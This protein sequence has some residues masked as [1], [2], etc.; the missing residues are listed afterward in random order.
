MS[1][2]CSSYSDTLCESCSSVSD[3]ITESFLRDCDYYS[4]SPYSV[5]S[6]VND[7]KIKEKETNDARTLPVENNVVYEGSGVPSVEEKDVV[8]DIHDE[9]NETIEGSGEIHFEPD[10]LTPN[11][12]TSVPIPVIPDESE[13][14]TEEIITTA[15]KT[16]VSQTPYPT[17]KFSVVTSESTVTTRAPSTTLKEGVIIIDSGIILQ[18]KTDERFKTDVVVTQAP[19]KASSILTEVTSTIS[20]STTIKRI[21][22]DPDK[23]ITIPNE[24]TTKKKGKNN[25]QDEAILFILN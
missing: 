15:I 21:L 8:Y 22:V 24:A 25:L 12:T 16:N 3:V 1:V 2:P 19:T 17:T 23:G 7:S 14:K 5:S 18:N 13:D 11:Q 9:I 10:T 20:D 4:D 6:K